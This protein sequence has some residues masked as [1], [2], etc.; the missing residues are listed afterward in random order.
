MEHF[1]FNHQYKRWVRNIHGSQK[2]HFSKIYLIANLKIQWCA[3]WAV[4]PK[5]AVLRK[6]IYKLLPF[7]FWVNFGWFQ[8]SFTHPLFSTALICFEFTTALN[9]TSDWLLVQSN[10]CQ[11][12]RVLQY[13]NWSATVTDKTPILRN[14][15]E[16]T[17][18]VYWPCGG[19][20]INP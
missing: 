12:K 5:V 8:L 10:V 16:I 11:G 17:K 7:Q 13:L 1:R 15:A 19:H 9:H 20:N 18:V 6:L 3:M 2:T 14:E 4:K